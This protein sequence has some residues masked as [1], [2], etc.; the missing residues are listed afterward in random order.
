[1]DKQVPN[2]RSKFCI[3]R[4]YWSY[5]PPSTPISGTIPW[6][7]K[8]LCILIDVSGSTDNTIGASSNRRN[9]DPETP[10]QTKIIIFAELEGIAHLLCELMSQFDF[11]GTHLLIS[12]FSTSYYKCFSDT[13]TSNLHMISTIKKLD[14]YVLFEGAT[15]DLALALDE[16]MKEYHEEFFLILATDGQPNQK[17]QALNVLKNSKIPF[18]IVVIGAGSI[19]EN[20][21]D[22]YFMM[23]RNQSGTMERQIMPDIEP[24]GAIEPINPIQTK[25]AECDMKYCQ[26]LVETATHH[27]IY[28]GAYGDYSEIHSVAQQ[29]IEMFGFIDK[30]FIVYLDGGRPMPLPKN[31]S[32]ALSK[33]SFVI[34]SVKINNHYSYYLYVY[35]PQEKIC[36]QYAINPISDIKPGECIAVAQLITT[37]DFYSMLKKFYMNQSQLRF[38]T[39]NKNFDVVPPTINHN[40][41]VVPLTSNTSDKLLFRERTIAPTVDVK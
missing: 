5:I 13:I 32:I 8:N 40:F 37:T 19:Q 14:E 17:Q 20:V 2:V 30:K 18:D 11:T 22:R 25:S 4:G 39:S 29:Y 7:Y 16:I 33:N 21:T 38:I 23:S 3:D 24:I 36:K 6:P 10:G 15:T 34:G 41:D 12:S 9:F 26:E 1:M 31:I 28:V 27:G 35:L